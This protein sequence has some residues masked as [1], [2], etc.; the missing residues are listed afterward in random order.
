MCV[1]PGDTWEIS[2]LPLRFATSPVVQMVRNLPAMGRPAFD[3]SA[4]KIPLEKEMATD[5]SFSPGESHGQRS[6]AGYSLWGRKESN[7]TEQ[8]TL[9]HF[10]F[11]TILEK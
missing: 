8:L 7:K 10:S 1:G 3:P 2:V 6:L 4:G 9:S 11:Q 5:S